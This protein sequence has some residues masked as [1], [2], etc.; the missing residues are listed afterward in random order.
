MSAVC[1]A[2]WWDAGR[3]V[4]APDWRPSTGSKLPC[5]ASCVS[6]SILRAR[7][8]Q[9][10]GRSASSC[11]PPSCAS[12]AGSCACT[13][14]PQGGRGPRCAA[15]PAAVVVVWRWCRCSPARLPLWPRSTAAPVRRASSTPAPASAARPFAPAARRACSHCAR[16]TERACGSDNVLDCGQ[17]HEL[18]HGCA[19]CR[20]GT[21]RPARASSAAQT[22]APHLICAS[23]SCTSRRRSTG[24]ATAAGRMAP[25]AV[26]FSSSLMEPGT[27]L[28]QQRAPAC[29]SAKTVQSA[30]RPATD[31]SPNH[32]AHGGV[33]GALLPRLLPR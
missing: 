8:V 10:C 3:G 29:L 21:R 28:G 5:A 14:G 2:P 31:A 17:R 4:S 25:S 11:A 1:T 16:D 33:L 18:A 12:P 6:S 32:R 23:S 15:A 27:P 20:G 26:D 9:A 7:G 24:T 19:A 30:R 22:H 13:Q